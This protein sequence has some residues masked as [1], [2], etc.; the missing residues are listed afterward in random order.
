VHV[1]CGSLPALS[2]SPFYLSNCFPRSSCTPLSFFPSSPQTP[3]KHLVSVL[4]S[5]PIKVPGLCKG[6]PLRTIFLSSFMTTHVPRWPLKHPVRFRLTTNST[7]SILIHTTATTDHKRPH[8]CLSSQ[9]SLQDGW[10]IRKQES[11]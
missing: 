2:L 6:I 9:R 8:Q 5:G 11:K 4:F 7:R 1:M 10:K 3:Q